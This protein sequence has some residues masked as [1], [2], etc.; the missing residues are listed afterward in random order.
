MNN[1]SF[2]RS[3]RIYLMDGSPNGRM[4]CELSNWTGRAYKIPRTMI[5]ECNGRSEL[6]GT[7]VYLLFGKDPANPEQDMVY[8]RRKQFLEIY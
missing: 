3:I 6:L 4:T 8:T 7:G 1:K 2:G 5:K